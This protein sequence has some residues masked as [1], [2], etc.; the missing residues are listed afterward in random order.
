MR[1]GCWKDSGDTE[2]GDVVKRFPFGFAP[3]AASEQEHHGHIKKLF[4]VVSVGRPDDAFHNQQ[5]PAG[6]QGSAAVA[7][8]FCGAL[9]I[10]IVDDVLHDVGVGA[11]WHG[12]E[13]ISAH[14]FAT[15]TER[16]QY[17]VRL[18]LLDY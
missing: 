5:L 4:R 17:G 6:F 8:D 15:V 9:I 16:R 18:R 7:E 10:P 1:S 3:L 13:E 14:E 12:V 2:S 11:R